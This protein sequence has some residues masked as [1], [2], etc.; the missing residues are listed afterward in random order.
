MKAYEEKNPE[1]HSEMLA[2]ALK[3][4]SK[5]PVTGEHEDYAARFKD[6]FTLMVELYGKGSPVFQRYLETRRH[7]G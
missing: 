1:W 7:D 5:D 4:I 3:G 2:K 6:E